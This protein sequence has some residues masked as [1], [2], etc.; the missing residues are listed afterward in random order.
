MTRKS[1]EVA[2]MI[3]GEYRGR[4]LGAEFWSD[5]ALVGGDDGLED[6]VCENEVAI[7]EEIREVDI[8]DG[9]GVEGEGGVSRLEGTGM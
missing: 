7:G 4:T 2:V 8:P 6:G 5:G 9:V 3:S 1:I